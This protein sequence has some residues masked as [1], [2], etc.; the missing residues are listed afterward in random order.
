M[1]SYVSLQL[2]SGVNVVIIRFSSKKNKGK[3]IPCPQSYLKAK[4][5][6]IGQWGTFTGTKKLI[7][8]STKT[9]SWKHKHTHTKKKKKKKSI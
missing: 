6:N 8:I 1:W 7:K 9:Q 2:Y 4:L 5:W 3:C